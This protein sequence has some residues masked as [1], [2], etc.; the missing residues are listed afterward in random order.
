[1]Q[2]PLFLDSP[3]VRWELVRAARKPWLTILV[4]GY[5]G[6]LFFHALAQVPSQVPRRQYEADRFERQRQEAAN[7]TIAA[8]NAV[9]SLLYMQ[10]LLILLVTPAITAGALG[11]EKESDTLEA[12]LCTELTSRAIVSG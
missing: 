9:S 12:L 2:L 7:K 6:F 11:Y 4:Y 3:I 10:L 1:M 8:G 5:L